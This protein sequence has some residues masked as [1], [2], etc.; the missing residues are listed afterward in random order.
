[1]E[2]IIK[3]LDSGTLK[4]F[5][6]GKLNVLTAVD[7]RRELEK[8]PQGTKIVFDFSDVKYISSAGL[9]EILICRKKFL[10]MRIENMRREVY[11]L[12]LMTGFDEFIPIALIEDNAPRFDVSFKKFLRDK[13]IYYGD[14]VATIFNGEEYTW[15]DMEHCSKVIANELYKNGVQQGN[16]VAICGANS[17]NR[18]LTFFATQRLGAIAVLIDSNLRAE[19]IAAR[20][21]SADVAYFCYGEIPA[22][23]NEKIFIYEIQKHSGGK[24]QIFYSIRDDLNFKTR[25]AG[26]SRFNVIVRAEDPTVMIFPSGTSS[27][28]LSARDILS[29]DALEE[30]FGEF[31]GILGR[32]TD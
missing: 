29:G 15:Q 24:I 1:M 20:V 32:K 31:A 6:V 19:E 28:L 11:M 7:F 26:K 5:V 27:K 23:S 30:I 3:Q 16:H 2:I 14:D 12:F 21:K 9:S 4:I 10:D 25:L 17:I 13:A 8:I 18:L 22:M